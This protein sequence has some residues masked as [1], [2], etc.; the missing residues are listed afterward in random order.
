MPVANG[1]RVITADNGNSLRDYHHR[2]AEQ[3]QPQDVRVIVENVAAAGPEV[4]DSRPMATPALQQLQQQP[5]GAGLVS[6]S[7]RKHR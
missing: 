4:Q 2:L 1:T 6:V 5:D 7:S 3:Q